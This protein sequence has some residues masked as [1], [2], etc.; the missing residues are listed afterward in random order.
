MLGSG[1]VRQ[2]EEIWYDDGNVVL[3]AEASSFRVHKSILARH[4]EF[5]HD[6]FKLPQ[7]PQGDASSD[8]VQCPVVHTSES[9]EDLAHFLDAIYNSVKSVQ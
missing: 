3:I 6:M 5:F 8:D 2:H 1:P 7:P 4:S 9:A